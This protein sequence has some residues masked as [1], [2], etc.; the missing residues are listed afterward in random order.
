[1][2]SWNGKHS[3]ICSDVEINSELWGRISP[4]VYFLFVSA[5]ASLSGKLTVIPST[6]M[7][8]AFSMTSVFAI[9]HVLTSR[10]FVWASGTSSAVNF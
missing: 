2:Y 8:I 10:P 9:F 1:M 7:P 5:S 4:F 6:P 3:D